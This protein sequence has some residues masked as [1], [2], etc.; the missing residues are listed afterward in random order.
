L[1]IGYTRRESFLELR[2]FWIAF[3]R[4]IPLQLIKELAR[5]CLGG[6]VA[7]LV[8]AERS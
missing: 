7:Q 2:W 8:R 3:E 1:M 4:T 6:P 5:T